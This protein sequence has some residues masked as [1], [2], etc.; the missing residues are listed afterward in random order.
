[1]AKN[2]YVKTICHLFKDW[3]IIEVLI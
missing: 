2:G 1:M 3:V